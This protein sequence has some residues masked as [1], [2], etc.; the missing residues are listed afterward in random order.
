MLRLT[1]VLVDENVHLLE[2]NNQQRFFD[3]LEEE[4]AKAEAFYRQRLIEAVQNFYLL[5]Q[6][7]CEQH[8]IGNFVPYQVEGGSRLV[9]ELARLELQLDVKVTADQNTARDMNS[10]S[11]YKLVPFEVGMHFEGL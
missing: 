7:T 9:R 4:V 3:V 10:S 6:A 5:V 1:G 8:L 2:L 11:D